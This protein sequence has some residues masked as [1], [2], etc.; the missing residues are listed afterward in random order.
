MLAFIRDALTCWLCVLFTCSGAAMAGVAPTVD[1]DATLPA[2][3]LKGYRYHAEILGPRDAPVVIVLHGGPG[4]DYRYLEPLRALADRYRVVFYD[5][6]GTGLSARVPAQAITP[7]SFIEDL[8]DW[9]EHVRQPG[10]P[11]MLVGHS[12]GAMLA[13]VYLGRHPQKVARAVLA[14]P[15]FLDA[16]TA[17][18]FTQPRWPGWHALWAIARA[19][20]GQWLVSTDGDAY[21]RA[22]WF[23]SQILLDMQ[24][25]ENLCNG[26]LPPVQMWRAGSSN[27]EATIGRMQ[28]EPQW[29]QSLSFRVG[30]EQFRKPVQFLVG[31]CSAITGAAQQRLH[32]AHF[33][34]AQMHEVAAAGHYLF[35][36][37]P[38]SSV[39]AVRVFLDGEARVAT[40][41]DQ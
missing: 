16:S 39:A 25:R 41:P 14:E 6:R 5:Q 9:V 8:D 29:A 7:D 24:P 17:S 30:V 22:D 38:Q 28:R 23:Y 36:D 21:A 35:N 18:A 3:T 2:V 33:A 37:Q 31:S 20:L 1:Q 32:I 26:E 34:N 15:G 27:I 4:A 12:W 19:W 11:V 13:S 10:Q 40:R